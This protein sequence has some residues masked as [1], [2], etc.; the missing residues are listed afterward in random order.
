[1]KVLI[2]DDELNILKGLNSFL[3]MM[4]YPIDEIQIQTDSVEAL[5]LAQT[6]RPDIT[7]TDVNMPRMDGFE[8]VEKMRAFL[9][10]M[11]VVIISC[12]DDI[13]Y[14][15][16]A[17]KLDAIDYIFK[18]VDTQELDNVMRRSLSRAGGQKEQSAQLESYFASFLTS[19]EKDPAESETVFSKI[20]MR[21]GKEARMTVGIIARDNG[22]S[23]R[24]CADYARLLNQQLETAGV[25]FA[26][27]LHDHVVLLI[28][29]AG[30]LSDRAK[31][32][33]RIML[34]AMKLGEK[35]GYRAVRAVC[36]GFYSR[37]VGLSI[38]YQRALDAIWDADRARSGYRSIDKVDDYYL[39]EIH[40]VS[41]DHIDAIVRAICMSDMEQIR[42]ILCE[43]YDLMNQR[44]QMGL[45][46]AYTEIT[47]LIKSV[48]GKLR[49]ISG[50]RFNCVE[51][52]ELQSEAI[53]NPQNV[54]QEAEKTFQW[55]VD[56]YLAESSRARK[57]V[58]RV[59]LMIE[60]N[61]TRSDFNVQYIAR[62]IGVGANY[63][64]AL[65]KSYTG[66]GL[67]ETITRKRIEKAKELMLQDQ[68]HLY[69]ISKMVGIEDQNYFSRIFKKYCGMRPVEYR[70]KL[71]R[72][73]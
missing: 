36:G 38:A 45:L 28:E 58:D 16:K 50:D 64:S 22:F 27:P 35:S 5:K 46:S 20:G 26:L 65:F 34:E 72:G 62:G 68:L 7:I 19:G 56:Q 4:D 29:T 69:Q 67:N 17:F 61:Y 2:V 51:L 54:M 6:F 21:L 39:D 18:P 48:L 33:E 57:L 73:K 41:S 3:I 12:H 31:E 63:L 44:N 9:P 1:M 71:L 37:V 66:N 42:N 30:M 43:I 8:M 15:K 14:L 55:L 11:H 24:Q 47:H 10:D 40:A 60:E 23:A 53:H 32:A 25:H 59:K 49:E 13:M 70:E 52:P